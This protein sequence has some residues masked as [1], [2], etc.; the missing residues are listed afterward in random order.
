MSW[1]LSA[2]VMAVAATLFAA[3][4]AKIV[5]PRVLST[6]IGMRLPGI[7]LPATV[8]PARLLGVLEAAVAL[9]LVSAPTSAEPA[10]GAVVLG[11]AFA[12]VSIS[13]RLR[14]EAVACGCFGGA[15]RK[16]VG[17]VHALLAL[18]LA[19]GGVTDLYA[20]SSTASTTS[21]LAMVT[22]GIV[23]V[24]ALANRS[25]ISSTMGRLR[26]GRAR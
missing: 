6:L 8:G 12:C 7:P 21:R 17:S 19:A 24:T 13:L 4:V 23:V 3:G 22:V 26:Q 15:S 16:P 25:E 14:G 10:I 18:G 9:G 5:A 1:L 2:V 11:S 20:H